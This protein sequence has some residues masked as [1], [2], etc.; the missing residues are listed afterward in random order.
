MTEEQA[1]YCRAVKFCGGQILIFEN[2]IHGVIEIR[3]KLGWRLGK[4]C[5]LGRH[6]SK[7][8]DIRIGFNFSQKRKL[9]DIV[10]MEQDAADKKWV[11][12]VAK[13]LPTRR[14][15]K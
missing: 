1:K 7:T 2:K 10:S 12:E 6:N 14:K 5:G 3:T 4:P 11:G 15:K 13:I 8:R 9:E